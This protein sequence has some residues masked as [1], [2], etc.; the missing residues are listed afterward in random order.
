M[1]KKVAQLI[2]LLLALCLVLLAHQAPP[3]ARAVSPGQVDSLPGPTVLIRLDPQVRQRYVAPPAAFQRQLAAADQ[4]NE[5]N[6]MVNYRGT[7]WT[8]DA[9]TAFEYAASIWESS[10]TSPV[11]I[12]VEAQFG[13][14]DPG[15]LGGAGP[16][17]IWRDFANAPQNNTW[18]PIATANKLANADLNPVGADIQATFSSSYPNWYF[19]TGNT[20]P[21]DKINFSTVVLHELGHGLGFLGSM[22]VD[23]GSESVECAGIAGVGCYGYSG[24]PSIYDRYTENG[25]GTALLD[26]SNF[27]TDLANQ[28]TSNGVFFDSPAAN[29]ANGGNRVPL[30]APP[31]WQ[32]GSSYSHLGE[33]YNSTPNALMTFSISKGETIHNP[34]L[35]TLCMFKDMGWTVSELCGDAAITGLSAANDGPTLLGAPTKLTASVT[36]G[37]NANYEWDF[38]DGNSGSGPVVSHTYPAPGTYM[39]EITASNA[40]G[41]E[42]AMTT[43]LV[44]EAS[45]R[46]YSPLVI[47]P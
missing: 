1:T 14:L 38:G 36:S 23:D 42:S 31:S 8:E 7:G 19:G 5:A 35:V 34:G 26:F 6:I 17:E 29:F 24:F 37:S 15:I 46:I 11:P 2:L 47:M 41:Q 44:F 4:A 3:A 33:S 20:T 13:P 25:A 12:V 32:R 39:A 40:V 43:V 16:T 21:A 10:I 22:R 45:D 9:Q 18:Y 28:L 27:S 30:F